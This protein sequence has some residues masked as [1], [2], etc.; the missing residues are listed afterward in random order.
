MPVTKSLML[1]FFVVVILTLIYF[2][3]RKVDL[4]LGLPAIIKESVQGNEEG[5]DA[6]YKRVAKNLVDF[7]QYKDAHEIFESLLV[8][9]DSIPTQYLY[10]FTRLLFLCRGEEFV[11]YK[12]PFVKLILTRVVNAETLDSET[13]RALNGIDKLVEGFGKIKDSE[14]EKIYFGFLDQLSP[15]QLK[16]FGYQSVKD[17]VYAGVLF[18]EAGVTN[19]IKRVLDLKDAEVVSVFLAVLGDE[20]SLR[21]LAQTK[22]NDLKHI[23]LAEFFVHDIFLLDEDFLIN[24]L[25]V[26]DFLVLTDPGYLESFV[27][28]RITDYHKASADAWGSLTGLKVST[29]S[30]RWLL[31]QVSD[32]KLLSSLTKSSEDFNDSSYAVIFHLDTL[33]KSL[34]SRIPEFVKIGSVFTD[35]AS[36]LFATERYLEDSRY[37]EITEKLLERGGGS[38]LKQ[39]A[40]LASFSSDGGYDIF[41]LE[42]ETKG[43]FIALAVIGEY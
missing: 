39:M 13:L 21:S 37:P 15:Q 34:K 26:S 22:Q 10:S 35:T 23:N 11:Q 20:P 27:Q 8:K 3:R 28:G 40:Y 25:Q 1:I 18:F 38:T 12:E 42:S 4:G 7:K 9:F 41:G 2:F 14:S 31:S 32:K 16:E 17:L 24:D 5:F 6:E 33:E 43:E 19:P 30:G 36:V 29:M